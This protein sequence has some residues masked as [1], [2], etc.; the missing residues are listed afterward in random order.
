M[1]FKA[2]ATLVGAFASTVLAHGTVTGIKVDGVYQPG[3]SLDSYY[4]AQSGQKIPDIAAWSA[5]NL[6]NG[7]VAP[8]AYGTKDIGCHIKAAP[9]HTSMPVKAGGTIEFQWSQWPDSHIGPVLTYVAKCSGSCTKA[10]VSTLKWV[11]IDAAGLKDGTWAATDLIKNNNTWTTTVPTSLAAGSYVFRHEIIALHGAASKNGAQNYPQCFNIDIKGN[12]TDNPE[13]TLTTKLYTETEPGILFDPYKGATK[14]EIP[15]P[16]MYKAGSSKPIIPI[17]PSNST[18]PAL[19]PTPTPIVTPTG[20]VTSMTPGP[21][22]QARENTSS[23]RVT[24][25]PRA[26][27]KFVTMKVRENTSSKLATLK[28][29]QATTTTSTVAEATRD[30]VND[31]RGCEASRRHVGQI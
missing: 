15:G 6:D 23:R 10:D 31:K 27:K 12:G 18:M 29:R 1:S 5:E 25:K 24:L 11:K 30:A 7:F 22:L 3:Y 21:A 20:F 8:A 2:A 13:G 19:T 4:A 9:G 28:V 17:I 26:T 16:A 14:Y